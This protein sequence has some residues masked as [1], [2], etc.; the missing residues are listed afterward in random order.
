MVENKVI[1]EQ[2]LY[3]HLEHKGHDGL[4]H[5]PVKNFKGTVIHDHDKSYYSYGSSHQECLAHVLRYLVGAT[6]SEPHLK[7]H[8]QMHELLQKMIH[9][10]KKNKSGVPKE[11]VK[12]LQSSETPTQKQEY[13]FQHAYNILKNNNILCGTDT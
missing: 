6:E 10:A 4:S 13:R 11:K 3:Q 9:T 12:I 5:T 1:K 2:V 7:W 8:K